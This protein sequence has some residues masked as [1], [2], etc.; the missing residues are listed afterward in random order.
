MMLAIDRTTRVESAPLHY[1]AGEIQG[2]A[3]TLQDT[4]RLAKTV[5][6][7]FTTLQTLMESDAGKALDHFRQN[8]AQI[9][10]D[11]VHQAGSDFLQAKNDP[12][13]GGRATGKLSTNILLAAAP[14]PVPSRLFRLRGA[15]ELAADAPKG[16]PELGPFPN[17]LR[18]PI[19]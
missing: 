1:M 5:A 9:T 15:A 12:N 11:A 2:G 16:A 18:K 14:L 13:H 19:E 17:K 4:A 8:S 3:E 7:P 6:Q 10:V